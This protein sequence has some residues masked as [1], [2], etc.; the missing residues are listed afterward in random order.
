MESSDY[1]DRL[2]AVTHSDK[3]PRVKAALLTDDD[4]KKPKRYISA[5]RYQKD[6]QTKKIYANKHKMKVAN[7]YA[8]FADAKLL[9]PRIYDEMDQLGE[10]STRKVSKELTKEPRKQKKRKTK[11]KT[12]PPLGK[13]SAD[14]RAFHG[15]KSDT[16]QPVGFTDFAVE[17]DNYRK[18]GVKSRSSF[19]TNLKKSLNDAY[20][21]SRKEN[22][23]DG[24][25]PPEEDA[26]QAAPA[27]KGMFRSSG[28]LSASTDH[29]FSTGHGQFSHS[30][31]RPSTASAVEG[32]SGGHPSLTQRTSSSRHPGNVPEWTTLRDTYIRQ[33]QNLDSHESTAR[34]RGMNSDISVPNFIG[35][36]LAIR[37]IS[38]RI[39]DAYRSILLHREGHH[40]TFAALHS[41]I[42]KMAT[43]VNC[44]NRQPFVD[45]MGITPVYNTF[46]SERRI[47]GCSA[48]FAPLDKPPSGLKFQGDSERQL[49]SS[50]PPG[51][52]DIFMHRDLQMTL[53]E[54]EIVDEMGQ[55]VWTAYKN[56]MDMLRYRATAHSLENL[57]GLKN[58]LIP[59][60]DEVSSVQVG[61][62]GLSVLDPAQSMYPEHNI[63]AAASAVDTLNLFHNV[64]PLP[65]HR[66]GPT[67]QEFW[68]IWRRTYRIKVGLRNLIDGRHYC[69]K[70]KVL[71][72]W[73]RYSWQSIQFRKMQQRRW[74]ELTTWTFNAWLQY[75]HW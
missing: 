64:R 45:W 3:I 22:D 50:H 73:T 19:S 29:G 33:L 6:L 56:H 62:N 69:I 20:L 8:D 14:E 43:D 12:M 15:R 2:F 11:Y 25:G 10:R 65:P 23:T 57:Y 9:S 34:E 4:D 36:L 52:D 38:F 5:R 55:V 37:K 49:D 17:V 35:L 59:D 70:R 26:T 68:D 40:A 13:L 28:Y 46:F 61:E 16:R 39:V 31:G 44:I 71:E 75:M 42:I 51:R 27:D 74:T 32:R 63:V 30:T 72:E 60:G 24:D 7:I 41:Y 53:K 47:D 67:L 1:L 54:Q 18:T 21:L 58:E 66:N 48:L